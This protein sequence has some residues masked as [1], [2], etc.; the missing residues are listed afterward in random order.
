MKILRS[1][2]LCGSMVAS[3]DASAGPP[4]S[5]AGKFVGVWRHNGIGQ[6]NKATLTADGTAACSENPACVQGTWTCNGNVLTYYNGIYPTD[7]TLQPNGIMTAR[8]GITVTRIGRGP[9]SVSQSSPQQPSAP[10]QRPEPGR[11]TAS[12][13][14]NQL[15]PV[16]GSSNPK[17]ARKSK[18]SDV[19]GTSG[20]RAPCPDDDIGASIN[21]VGKTSW[22]V[23]CGQNGSGDGKLALGF[24]SPCLKAAKWTRNEPYNHGDTPIVFT[25]FYGEPVVLKRRDT[26]WSVQDPNSSDGRKTVAKQ[27]TE[28][29][30]S[31]ASGRC[32]Q[33]SGT[34]AVDFQVS[35]ECERNRQNE[36]DEEFVSREDA[37]PYMD[38]SD[39]RPPSTVQL[40]DDVGKRDLGY[41]KQNPREPVGWCK[42]PRRDN[43]M[44]SR[45]IRQEG[46][47]TKKDCEGA[48][49]GLSSK[50][51]INARGV[52]GCTIADEPIR[53][54]LPAE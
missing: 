10:I 37:Y 35:I 44:D 14:A 50:L 48:F 13:T 2:L 23:T 9:S 43:R 12:N 26:L 22:G 42:T 8:G 29:Q 24:N 17:P 33:L 49:P 11:K 34:T 52:R 54:K 20:P 27:W 39:C 53:I 7:Y 45:P 41:W 25:P 19:S 21:S 6:T 38:K 46:W 30:V 4:S 36:Q 40:S 5:C 51:S 47:R 28:G 3:A 18:C 31:G 16:A 32:T 1:V 15:T